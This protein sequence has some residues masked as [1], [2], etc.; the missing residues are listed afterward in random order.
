LNKISV[1]GVN[2]IECYLVF[3]GRQIPNSERQAPFFVEQRVSEDPESW[4]I[5]IDEKKLKVSNTADTSLYIILVDIIQSMT[6]DL[7]E[8]AASYVSC[9]L[10]S[11]TNAIDE[12]LDDFG[13]EQ[14]TGDSRLSRRVFQS[15]CSTPLN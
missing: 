7:A 8:H 6:G 10:K 3:K 11:D 14:F 13:I 9:M 15:I 4:T 2:K 12:I 5:Y 1:I